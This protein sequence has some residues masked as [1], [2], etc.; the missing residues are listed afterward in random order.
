MNTVVI[1]QNQDETLHRQIQ[2]LTQQLHNQT[3]YGEMILSIG[4]GRGDHHDACVMHDCIQ[5]GL[6]VYRIDSIPHY[7]E[8]NIEDALHFL[9]PAGFSMSRMIKCSILAATNE[10]VSTR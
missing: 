7:I 8:T 6:Q 9:Y 5:S 2:E 4:E 10:Q 3:N 1:L